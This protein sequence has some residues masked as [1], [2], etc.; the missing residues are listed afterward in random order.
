MVFTGNLAP[1]QGVDVLL[2]AFAVASRRRRDIRLQIVT[3]F[4]FSTYEP[5]ARALGIRDLIEVVP[6]PAFADLPALLEAAHVAANPRIEADG[7]PVKL[8]NYMAAGKPI[9]SFEGS[10][11][12]LTAWRHRVAGRRRRSR[13]VRAGHPRRCSRTAERAQALGRHARRFVEQHYRWPVVAERIERV[14][15]AVLEPG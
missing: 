5:A 12:G 7:A 9:V 3:D 13:G 11:P 2:E 8:L 6:A 1:Y 14:Y 4:D 15:R 10:A